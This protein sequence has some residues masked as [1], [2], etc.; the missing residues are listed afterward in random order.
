MQGVGGDDPHKEPLSS[1]GSQCS[2]CCMTEISQRSACERVQGE[3]SKELKGR[4]LP[5]PS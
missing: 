2:G 4:L 1:R 5:K 3:M